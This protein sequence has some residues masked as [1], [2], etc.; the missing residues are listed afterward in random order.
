MKHGRDEGQEDGVDERVVESNEDER[1]A[2]QQAS[3]GQ[4][5]GRKGGRNLKRCK[6]GTVRQFL[7][8]LVAEAEKNNLVGCLSIIHTKHAGYLDSK[9]SH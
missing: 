2:K 6:Q 4:Q 7:C 5:A 9:N 1:I 8:A 3:C